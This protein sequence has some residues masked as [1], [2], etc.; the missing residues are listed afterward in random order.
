MKGAQGEKA[1]TDLAFLLLR[2]SEL[3]RGGI[4][5]CSFYHQG[6]EVELTR[7]RILVPDAVGAGNQVLSQ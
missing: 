4:F 5:S 2:T 6:S 3:K 1:P 7:S